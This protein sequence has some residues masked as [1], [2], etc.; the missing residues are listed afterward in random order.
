M[1]INLKLESRIKDRISKLNEDLE[2]LEVQKEHN[3]LSTLYQGL[4]KNKYRSLLQTIRI[5]INQNKY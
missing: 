2:V 5:S 1:I 4:E 3:G